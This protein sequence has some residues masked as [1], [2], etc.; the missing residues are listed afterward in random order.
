MN[1]HQPELSKQ[2]QHYAEVRRKLMGKVT[3]EQN[4]ASARIEAPDPLIAMRDAA[5]KTVGELRTL[6]S[7]QAKE[8]RFL[9]RSLKE[10]T[11]A[12]ARIRRLELDL[13]DARARILAQAEKLKS[14]DFDGF[15]IEDRRRPVEV[16]VEEVLRDYPGVTFNDVKGLRRTR[17]LIA[18]RHACIRAVFEERTDLSSVRIG[19]I[20]GNREHSTILHSLKKSDT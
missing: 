20:F 17:N 10:Q 6:V 5:V 11:A 2:A 4:K 19:K 12:D 7:R 3:P 8:I 14:D 18:P 16:I 15:G 9:K 1:M 13:A